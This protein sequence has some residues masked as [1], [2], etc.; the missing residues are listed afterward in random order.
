MVFSIYTNVES[1]T[2]HIKIGSMDKYAFASNIS[3][4]STINE[5][6]WSLRANSLIVKTQELLQGQKVDV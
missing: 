1:S 2:S 4:I 6:K 5:K 3:V